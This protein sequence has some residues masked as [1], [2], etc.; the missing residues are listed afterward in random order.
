M[1]KYTQLV[2]TRG[3]EQEQGAMRKYTQC[4]SKEIAPFH[5]VG[6]GMQIWRRG[7]QETENL[8]TP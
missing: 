1:R 6:G 2:S 4:V 7:R 3:G 5:Q 8:N